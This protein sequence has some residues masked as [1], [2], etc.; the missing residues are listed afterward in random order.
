MTM[1]GSMNVR[2]TNPLSVLSV[3]HFHPETVL[4]NAF[5]ECLDIGVD[6]SWILERVGIRSRRT[7]LPLEYIRIT[8]NQDP[9]AADDAAMYSNAETGARAARVAMDRAG[10]TPSQIGMIIAGGCSPSYSIPAEAC[11]IAA[12]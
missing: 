6:A 4:D 5:L 7:V 12:Q 8:K 3:G 1:R 9:R 2:P 11:V 10:I